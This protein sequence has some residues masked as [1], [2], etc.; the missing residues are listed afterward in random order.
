M[1]PTQE[2]RTTSPY[3][4]RDYIHTNCG[5]ATT[6]AGGALGHLVNPFRYVNETRCAACGGTDMT[7]N[8][9]WAD[10]DECVDEFRSRVF[11]M[12]PL[13]VKILMFLLVP[14]IFGIGVYFAIPLLPPPGKNGGDPKVIEMLSVPFGF[15]VGM[16]TM[17]MTPLSSIVARLCGVNFKT[18]M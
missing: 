13:Y 1:P 14:L 10:T 3:A 5:G 2:Q 4:K 18:F 6:V 16:M 11:R 15:L 9:K 7:A 17:V 8:F 12:V